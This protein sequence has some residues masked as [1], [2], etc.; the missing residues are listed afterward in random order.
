MKTPSDS[1]LAL[2]PTMRSPV[3]VTAWRD[4]SVVPALAARIAAVAALTARLDLLRYSPSAEFEHVQSEL[5]S[6]KRDVDRLTRWRDEADADIPKLQA[7]AHAEKDRALAEKAAADAETLAFRQW[8]AT[9]LDDVFSRLAEGLALHDKL[10]AKRTGWYRRHL[11]LPEWVRAEIPM[12]LVSDAIF[13]ARQGATNLPQCVVI[14]PAFSDPDAPS[15]RA[16]HWPPVPPSAPQPPA[17][18]RPEAAP[19]VMRGRTVVQ[20]G[21]PTPPAAA[22]HLGPRG[23]Q[24]DTTYSDAAARAM[25]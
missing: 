7:A 10:T 11:S 25:V 19:Y 2:R 24:S 15:N 16:R 4:N 9:N 21:A 8:C 14:L 5:D 3:L 22:K 12:A 18:A 17:S 6:A 20:P 23:L 13:G 1:V